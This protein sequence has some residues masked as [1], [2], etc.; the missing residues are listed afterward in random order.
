MMGAVVGLSAIAL[1]ADEPL[2]YIVF[3]GLMW[4]ALRFGPQGDVRVI[5]KSLQSRLF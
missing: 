4:A 3:P 1:S 5:G 2:T